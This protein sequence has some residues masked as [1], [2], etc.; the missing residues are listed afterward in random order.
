M[1]EL[2]REHHLTALLIF[3][4]ACLLLTYL[5]DVHSA[6]CPFYLLLHFKVAD[7]HAF[8]PKYFSMHLIQ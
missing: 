5:L 3:Y 6:T 2:Y 7:I 8:S 1:N 4:C